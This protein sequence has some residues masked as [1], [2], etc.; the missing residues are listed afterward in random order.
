MS[1]VISPKPITLRA[2]EALPIEPRPITEVTHGQVDSESDSNTRSSPQTTQ[3]TNGKKDP[4]QS[5]ASGSQKA[6]TARS[7]SSVSSNTKKT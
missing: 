1:K 7:A 4:G 5:T 3:G 2:V 6:G